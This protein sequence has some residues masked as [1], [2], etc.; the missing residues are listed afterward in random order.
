MQIFTEFT[1]FNKLLSQNRN[2]RK[3][4]FQE[5]IF[6]WNRHEQ[7][8]N[9]KSS[10]IQKHILCRK[11]QLSEG[12]RSVFKVMSP[13]FTGLCEAKWLNDTLWKITLSLTAHLTNHVTHNIMAVINDTDDVSDNCFF[14]VNLGILIG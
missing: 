6:R 5:E 12:F 10:V 3:H 4:A 14:L 9:C 2:L 1:R 11:V 8:K 7:S 13:P